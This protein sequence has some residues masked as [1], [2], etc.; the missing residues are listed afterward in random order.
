MFFV[1]NL[2]ALDHYDW[3][4]IFVQPDTTHLKQEYQKY[5]SMSLPESW[6]V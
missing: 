3:L 1:T 5:F 6:S 4:K 2:S